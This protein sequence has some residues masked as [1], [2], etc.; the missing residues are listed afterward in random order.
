MAIS[1]LR[2]GRK[3]K[4][5][6]TQMRDSIKTTSSPT[7]TDIEKTSTTPRHQGNRCHCHLLFN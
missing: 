1:K 4:G 5:I 6:N 3:R 2:T 7:E